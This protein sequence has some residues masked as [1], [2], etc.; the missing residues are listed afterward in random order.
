V[1][2]HL[3]DPYKPFVTDVA[4]EWCREVYTDMLIQPPLLQEL[5]A[6]DLAGVFTV[7]GVETGVFA[8]RR[9]C[10]ELLPTGAAISINQS[11]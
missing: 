3:V 9:Y 4:G 11:I 5:S 2:L 8:Q 10:E 6:A 1:A 7:V